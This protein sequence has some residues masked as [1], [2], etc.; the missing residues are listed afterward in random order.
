M[1]KDYNPEELA[2][3]LDTLFTDETSDLSDIPD[4]PLVEVAVELSTSPAPQLSDA[5]RTEMRQKMMQTHQSNA[6]TLNNKKTIQFPMVS[7]LRWVAVFAV[8]IILMNN[9]AIPTMADSLPNDL[10]YPVKRGLESVELS[11]ASTDID[12]VQVHIRHAQRRLDEANRLLE[13]EIIP[14]RL[15]SEAMDSLNQ[16]S[17]IAPVDSILE[18]EVKAMLPVV[19]S[20]INN[21]EKT[22]MSSAEALLNELAPLFPASEPL[23]ENNEP[24]QIVT[25]TPTL[26]PTLTATS[27]ATPTL[28]STQT[29]T[30]T[31][32]PTATSTPT[33][34][35]TATS[36]STAT[37]T[38]TATLTQ[39]PK[40]TATEVYESYVGVVS[41]VSNVNIRTLPSTDSE[42]IQQVIPGTIITVIGESIDSQWLKIQIDSES[43]GWIASILIVEGTQPVFTIQE[44]ATSEALPDTG[45]TSEVTTSTNSDNNDNNNNQDSSS[46]NQGNDGI[47]KFGC[48]GQGNSCNSGNQGNSNNNS[49]KGNKDKNK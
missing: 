3:Y 34:T 49:N 7:I 35:L 6:P 41:A 32:T 38:A 25:A 30:A 47:N 29:V 48:D 36:T 12:K 10:L 20:I 16:A 19:A 1:T 23:Q 27:T 14:S 26:T 5:M 39:T 8:F 15:V 18:A 11:L 37:Q 43:E 21:I 40:P 28:T 45:T 13:A 4:N 42:V 44:E 24:Q 46:S 31:P 22:D 17:I 9:V 33:Q 2:Q